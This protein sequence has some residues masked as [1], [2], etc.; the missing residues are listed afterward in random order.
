MTQVHYYWWIK[1]WQFSNKIANRQ[2]LL[3]TNISSYSYSIYK[4]NTHCSRS[5][6]WI[7]PTYQKQT[8]EAVDEDTNGAQAEEKPL[9]NEATEL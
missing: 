7:N 4:F 6:K 3:L 9:D 5:Q 8:D 2:S 1:H